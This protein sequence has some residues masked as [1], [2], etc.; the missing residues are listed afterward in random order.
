MRYLLLLLLLPALC[1]AARLDYAG[2]LGN[3]GVGGDTLVRVSLANRSSDGGGL[4]SGVYLDRHLRV[5]TSGGDAINCLAFDG[6]LVKRYPLT[7]VGSRVDSTAFT[8]LD[9]V[10]YFLG[11]TPKAVGERVV[12]F[13]LPLDGTPDAKVVMTGFPT[14][15]GVLCPT[16]WNGKVLLGYG[17]DDNTAHVDAFDPKTGAR[18][19]LFTLAGNSIVGMAVDPA[20]N[21]LLV[22]GFFG[23]YVGGNIHQPY[24]HEIMKVDWD[25]KILWRKECLETPANP[26]Q[27]RGVVSC[28]GGALWDSAWY[29]FFARFDRQGVSAPGKIAS[30]DMRIPYASQTLD[31]RQGTALLP[32]GGPAEALD[33]LLIATH[34]PDQT[35]LAAWDADAQELRLQQRFGALP[36]L[37]NVYLSPDGWVFVG[38]HW[39]RFDDAANDVPRFANYVS[40]PMSPGAFRGD[41]VCMLRKT[42]QPAIP[43]VARPALGRESAQYGYTQQAPFSGTRGFAVSNPNAPVV[44]AYATAGNR[45]WRT[46]M[47]MAN[48]EPMKE[49]KPQTIDG[50]APADLGDIAVLPDGTL[51]VADGG[52]VLWLQPAGE[53]WRITRRLTAW[54]EAADQHFGTHLR[55]AAD[56][57][58]LLVSD[59]DRHRV[60]L[61]DAATGQPV[62]NY[63]ATDTPGAG[64]GQLNAPGCVAIAGSRAIVA[65]VGN[66]RVVKLRLSDI[67]PPKVAGWA[68]RKPVVQ[69]A[70]IA[71]W[72]PAPEFLAWR[73]ADARDGFSGKVLRVKLSGPFIAGAWSQHAGALLLPADPLPAWM[74][75]TVSFKARRLAGSAY[76][77]LYRSWGGSRPWETIALTDTWRD[78]AV[79]RTADHAT[80]ML[81]FS[82]V[83]KPGGLQPYCAGEFEV[84]DVRIT[85][86]P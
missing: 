11:R 28:A 82:L 39:W 31:V 84:A 3:S 36:E 43:C 42:N 14:Y 13:A 74:P 62:W 16:P 86:T 41:W 19:A 80:E 53:A 79:R 81:T 20:D 47:H 9:G 18:T 29:G 70:A 44:W 76:L 54:G 12:L 52:S 17:L 58:N 40:A 66:Q 27:F 33:P 46:R 51:V 73:D 71:A 65:D 23:K 38:S 77:T 55:L 63:G 8:V 50:D 60:V 64:D 69:G 61:L 24:V 34:L 25:G 72:A 35:Y 57:N 67:A 26:T 56:G 85:Y 10:L 7:P 4:N 83:H 75:Y 78:Y 2:V 59:T 45:L 21:A 32:A 48:W 49:W 15:R 30:W 37:D 22:G 68:S 5:W 6:R 1:W